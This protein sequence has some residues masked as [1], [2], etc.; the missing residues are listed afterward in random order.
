[1]DPTTQL[2]TYLQT[3]G[4]E[5]S[6]VI[7][8]TTLL[9]QGPLPALQLAKQTDISRTQVYRSLEHLQANSLVVPVTLQYGSLFR[10]LPIEAFDAQL[11]TREQQT[12]QLRQQLN[13]LTEQMQQ[14]GKATTHHHPGL[15]GIK[16]AIWDATSA[17]QECRIISQPGKP[18][19]N[20][21]QFAR[22]VQEQF[23]EG[24]Q[25]VYVITNTE[26]IA[27]Q[28]AGIRYHHVDPAIFN[29]PI[30][31]VLYDGHMTLLDYRPDTVGATVISHPGL[32]TL[33]R[34]LFETLWGLGTPIDAA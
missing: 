2:K 9:Q 22:R 20:D 26:H 7:I 31:T 17:T 11:A 10:A 4:I 15:T 5:P 21:S 28:S 30:D 24:G 3:A 18:F 12:K 13:N 32:F 6:A 25:N 27:D 29:S 23:I 16:Q 1:M 8:Y 34:Q 19:G 14:E 33:Q